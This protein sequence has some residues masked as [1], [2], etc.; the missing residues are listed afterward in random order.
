MPFLRACFYYGIAACDWTRGQ[1]SKEW[2]QTCWVQRRLAEEKF[3]VSPDGIKRLSVAFCARNRCTL[4]ERLIYKFPVV[5]LHDFVAR[6]ATKS[7]DLL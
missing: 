7:K 1:R 4:I 2:Q 3:K 5:H 6:D